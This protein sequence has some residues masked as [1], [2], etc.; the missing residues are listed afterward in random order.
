M[1]QWER[2]SHFSSHTSLELNLL[3]LILNC[4]STFLCSFSPSDPWQLT[5]WIS[6]CLKTKTIPFCF[7]LSK[8]DFTV[9]GGVYGNKE[10][11]AF[12]NLE[13]GYLCIAHLV[14]F[15]K[16]RD[17]FIIHSFHF[18]SGRTSVFPLIGDISSTRVVGILCHH[19][20]AAR[21][22]WRLASTCR[23]GHSV[24]SHHRPI[25][26]QSTAHQPSVLH[27]VRSVLWQ[28]IA[29]VFFFPHF[30]INIILFVL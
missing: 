19:S 22:T 10:D 3:G 5:R 25:C 27:W 8:D 20:S 21:E 4:G 14:S 30:K 28:I 6:F 17:R 9:F 2:L 16:N 13:V 15:R 26:Q 11:S 7:Q 24:P 29:N 1:W 23:C 18:S 12:Q